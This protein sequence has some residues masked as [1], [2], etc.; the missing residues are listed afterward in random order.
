MASEERIKA[1]LHTFYEAEARDLATDEWLARGSS[2]LIPEKQASQY[3]VE[4]KVKTAVD[5]AGLS[6]EARILEIGCS[7]GHMTFHLAPLFREVVAIDL[8]PESVLLARRRAK[9][10][11]VD[12]VE[13]RE[14]D[15]EN[16]DFGDG[17]FDGVFSFSTLRFC[18]RPAVALGEIR[19]V[20]KPGGRA[21]IDFPNRFSPWFG[22]IKNLLGIRPHIH[23]RLFSAGEVLQLL[24]AAGF[25]E[26][27]HRHMLFTS[28]RVPDRA[29]PA[30]K[31]ADRLLEA[32][33]LI[34][35]LSGIIMAA[36]QRPDA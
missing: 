27:R 14:G 33:P 16:L 6:H 23:D 31:L 25:T 9:H 24:N 22:L 35:N 18:P 5:L 26:T 28:R 21:A 19:R 17:E 34:R 20:L 10:Y 32:A 7:F 3:F 1:E 30:F 12:N 29:L 15:A 13:F 2:P 8:S 36:G 4:R 11:G